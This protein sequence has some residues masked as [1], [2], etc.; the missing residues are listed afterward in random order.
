MKEIKSHDGIS[1]RT[2]SRR[3]VSGAPEKLINI[4]TL[5]QGQSLPLLIKPAMEGVNLIQW[6]QNNRQFIEAQLFKYGGILFR[7]FDVKEVA[8]F[9][10]FVQA[11]SNELLSYHE[12]SSPRSRISGNIYTSTDYPA[13]QSIFLHNENSYQHIFPLKIFFFC[14]TPAQSGG[15]TPIADCRGVLRRIDPAIQERF[16]EKGGWKLVRNFGDDVG[17]SWQTTFQTTNEAG[18]ERYCRNAGIATEWK[19]GRLRT[20]QV[21]PGFATHPTTGETVWFN[22][23]TFFHVSTLDPAVQ[24]ALLAQYEEEE[25]PNNTYYGDGS[26][27]EPAVLAH[28]RD[29]YLQEITMFQWQRSDILMLDN[30]LVAHGRRPFS[31]PRKIVVGMADPFHRVS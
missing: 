15:E 5:R 4:D 7:N 13:G 6:S 28:L 20:S 22:H 21:R 17:L 11:T 9:E 16:R 14:V 8:D 23:A 27:I 10:R 19:E 31:G 26:P 29:A 1:L 18:V 25:L 2:Y 3:P 24:Q 30:M 12:R